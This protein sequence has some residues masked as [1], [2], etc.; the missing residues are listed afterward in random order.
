M[1]EI[2]KSLFPAVCIWLA[3]TIA[4]IIW[5]KS[6]IR[7]LREE[8]DRFKKTYHEDIMKGRWK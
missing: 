1:D 8:L 3:Y 7:I 4:I 5:L 6:D 2:I